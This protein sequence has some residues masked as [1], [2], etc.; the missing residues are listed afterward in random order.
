VAAITPLS[1]ASAKRQLGIR[2]R[3]TLLFYLVILLS[4]GVVGYYGYTSAV[5]AHLGMAEEKVKG[6]AN[7]VSQKI[8]DFLD[9]TRSDLDFFAANSDFIRSLYWLDVGEEQHHKNWHAVAL[10][11]WLGFTRSYDYLFKVRFLDLQ[12][13]ERIS[14][15]RDPRT[16]EVGALADRELQDK[17]SERYFLD[18]LTLQ[19]G[20]VAV[21]PLDLNREH[22]KVEKP[23]VPVVRL[24]QPVF[25]ENQVKYGIVVIN[26]FADAFFDYIR[27][28][29]RKLTDGTLY[30]ID[31]NGDFL[32]HP[33]P[34]RSFAHLLGHETNFHTLFPGI[35][36]QLREQKQG[37][38]FT[39]HQV[40]GFKRIYPLR[41]N[42]EYYWILVD[43]ID[44][45]E[46]L[47][48][49]TTFKVFFIS[50]LLGVLVL[51][52]LVSRY[53]L[54]GLIQPLLF[55]TRQVDRL[56]RG[57]IVSES[58]E[59]RARD[60]MGRMLDSA[61]KL[62]TNMEALAGQADAIAAGDF[63]RSAPIL[64]EQDRLG[65][66]IDNMTRMLRE[67]REENRR[68]TWLRDGI[69]DLNRALAGELE[70]SELANR[71]MAQ[72]GR[73]LQAAHGVFY[74]FHE[75]ENT[76]D[77]LG[78][79]M[80]T[81]RDRLNQRLK[82]GEGSVGQVARERK[83]ILL[84]NIRPGEQE[85][86]TGIVT[87]TPLSSYTV[88]IIYEDRLYGVME[89]AAMRPINRQER[90]Y[91][92]E[93]TGVIGTFL[94]SVLQRQRIRELLAMAEQSAQKAEEK[95]RQLQ[96]VNT[97]MEEQQQQLQ[98]QTE[99]LQQTN[100][101]MEE[102]QQQLQQQTEELQQTNAQM[103]EQQQ[104]L[105]IQTRDMEQ[106][107]QEL[108]DSKQT[109][110]L[111]ARELEQASQYK[112]EFLANM[113][114]ELRT[115]LN[116]IILLSRML[117]MNEE[118]HLSPED[119]KRAGV[120]HHA[121]EELLRLI[122]DI[123]DLSKIESGKMEL[124]LHA[125]HSSELVSEYA[126]LFQEM[127]IE[128]GLEFRL[129]DKLQT[130]F[131][132]DHDKLSQ[133]IRNLL[134]NAFKFTRKGHVTLRLEPSG[135]PK[136]PVQIAVID[137]G[138]GIPEHKQQLIFEAFQQVDGSVSR[139]YGGTGLGL[140][141]SLRFARLLG[142]SIK[143]KSTP[144]EGSSFAVLLPDAKQKLKSPKPEPLNQLPAPMRNG[145]ARPTPEPV[146]DDRDRLQPSD[147]VILLID[148]DAAFGQAV[149]AINRRLGYKTLVAQS[150]EEGLRMAKAYRP[151]GILLDL[152]LPDR[153]GTEVL[154]ELKATRELRAIPIYI[155]SA[156][157]QDDNL[158]RRG[159]IGYL[160]K[161]VDD[162]QLADAE[163]RVL[164]NHSG[165]AGRLLVVEAGSLQQGEIERM[166]E[167]TDT[168]VQ[169]VDSA[170]AALEL[171]QTTPFDLAIVD[172]GNASIEQSLETCR[173]LR[174]QD[175]ALGILF[176]GQQQL[177][178]DDEARLRE[179]SDSIILKTAHAGR[180]LSENIE[181]FLREMPK[182]AFQDK[183]ALTSG[184]LSIGKKL[185]GRR[186]LVV[187]DD[188]RNLFVVTSA[189]EQQGA[190][191]HNALN[192]RKALAFLS[193]QSVDLV[194]MD[195]MMPEMDGYQTI[196]SL[197]ADP[198]LQHI[199]V[200]ALTAKALKEDRQKAM[201]A[202]ADDYL[203]KPVDYEILV[204]MASVWC[205]GG[206]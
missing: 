194:I 30:L 61:G 160:Q 49:L 41:E 150:A 77:L 127:A 130:T 170:R 176:Y 43:A 57:E 133:I 95:S 163:A 126:E 172:L 180:R 14:I 162:R 196:K 68:R 6:R 48:E 26:L 198:A 199:P 64:S 153:D 22:G 155:V 195:I 73:Y 39:H 186:I 167:Q 102:Q 81:E 3:F 19:K 86:S 72:V 138:I 128:K 36:E 137:S 91:L 99:E 16:R 152:G 156:R 114:H 187:D 166:V 87:T 116:S 8:E 134:S 75:Q 21:T 158:L 5:N 94:Y 92:D 182:H 193:T 111:K 101:Q 154:R 100:A 18:A 53:F 121:G 146:A 76:L 118:G 56:S 110:N 117:N 7:Q 74:L 206:A 71:A 37:T 136:L 179:Y 192:G 115:P 9:L 171:L 52:F 69:G 65:Q 84:R 124:N 164:A 27:Q 173:I 178:A 132:T 145:A 151:R 80:F 184:D 58:L 181:R 191:V 104:Q 149:A 20:A 165:G 189:L 28:A 112:S 188:P 31:S 66:A 175:P 122:N 103:E 50:I 183:K 89:L 2:A 47:R 90:E 24:A 129:E 168:Q 142:G 144:G 161:P 131:T 98:Q 159:I 169:T 35:I 148:D 82:P 85:V 108:L 174:A 157:D 200:V 107:N 4:M 96:E 29:N 12:G 105:E 120:I 44:K 88:P 109:L 140:T 70:P 97:Q 201:A 33:D 11:A 93:A 38:L 42:S 25:G 54:N 23:L 119:I 46:A 204:N 177:V 83:P 135:D 125:L 34:E 203:S 13:Q 185:E 17:G 79:Y 205:E 51:T 62:V 55:V 139:E 60:E 45:A 40:I 1:P 67:G 113:S 197:K 123:L 143:L 59:Y 147:Q 141:I 15:R 190:Q 106:Q 32:F 63:S 10:Q 78:S 202:G